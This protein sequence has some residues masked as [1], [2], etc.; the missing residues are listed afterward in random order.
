MAFVGMAPF[1][2]LLVGVMAGRLGATVA[3]SG[4]GRIE[5][6]SGEQAVVLHLA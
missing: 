5:T 6:R 4:A 2:S 1:G 3:V